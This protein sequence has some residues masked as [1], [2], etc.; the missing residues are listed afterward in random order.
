MMRPTIVNFGR[1][2]ALLCS[3]FMLVSCSNDTTVL[4]GIDVLSRDNFQPLH[5]SRVALITNHTG[6]DRHGQSTI[7]L[8]HNADNVEL[9]RIFGP[10]HSLSGKLDVPII[11]DDVDTS[12]GVEVLSLYGEVRRPT[13]EMLDGID[14]I[15]FDIQDIGARF[16]TYISTMGNAMQAA[17]DSHIKFVVLDRPNPINGVN[18]AGPMLD[19]GKQSFVGFHRLPVRHGMTVGE[20]ARLFKA[21]MAIDVELQVIEIQGWQRSE[22]FDATELPWIN[23]SPNIRNLTEA[24][25][26]PGIGLLETTN[27]SVG[28]GTDTPFE[29]F[30][31]PW[32]DGPALATYLNGAALPGISFE[33]IRFTP[34]ASKFAGEACAGVR[35]TITN[36]KIFDPLRVGLEIARY[37]AIAYADTWDVDAYRRLLGNDRTLQAV[38]DGLPYSE[39]LATYDDGLNA[40][41]ERRSRYLLYP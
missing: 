24:V 35:L 15:V 14:T 39:I 28:R 2:F 26:Y 32:I 40:F 21:E 10:E 30:G 31:A 38:R 4:T 36:R 3:L 7:R 17:A 22:Y 37:L 11:Q 16:Y 9:V 13:P 6:V 33:A 8:L 12:T 1:P 41:R 34:D 29:V 18:V 20:L 5:G 25:L 23:P 19:D 27:M